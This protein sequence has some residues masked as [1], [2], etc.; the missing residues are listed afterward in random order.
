[1]LRQGGAVGF[2]GSSRYGRAMNR[3]SWSQ[4]K[5]KKPAGWVEARK[6]GEPGRLGS[7]R[8][9]PVSR[10]RI[11]IGWARAAHIAKKHGQT[12]V[13]LSFAAANG[14]AFFA[15]WLRDQINRWKGL[16]QPN[17]V[18]LDAEA[19]KHVPLTR[20]VLKDRRMPWV[21]GLASMNEGW[22]GYYRHAIRQAD[23]M[24]FVGTSD[25]SRSQ[26]C[27]GELKDF[28]DEVAERSRE[29]RKPLNGIALMLPNCTEA[30]PGLT[31]IRCQ[32]SYP[33]PTHEDLWIVGGADLLRIM[34]ALGPLT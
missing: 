34:T 22:R 29:G 16:S 28:R 21:F 18:Y 6:P 9:D 11:D 5:P 3:T 25:W 20:F 4:T 17:E 10:S 30:F 8:F 2:S 14:G 19:L 7:H 32:R 33:S 26:W 27:R 13:V 24:I 23:A 31:H 1:M 15:Q 12:K